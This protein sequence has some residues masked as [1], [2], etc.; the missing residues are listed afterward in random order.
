MYG[1]HR[2]YGY[3]L[4]G[5]DPV[6]VSRGGAGASID[7]AKRQ[8]IYGVALLDSIKTKLDRT[9][10]RFVCSLTESTLTGMRIVSN[11]PRTPY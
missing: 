7:R 10:F 6:M 9:G 2:R 3:D 5:A 1:V 11:T 4:R 8:R